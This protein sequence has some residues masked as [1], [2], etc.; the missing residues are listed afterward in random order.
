M[1]PSEEQFE[2][3]I[4]QSLLSQGYQQRQPS[5]YDKARCLLPA[6][7]VAFVVATQPQEWAKLREHHRDA[8]EA[9]FR[10]RVASEVAKRGALD[11]LRK[12]VKD[13]GSR[14]DLAY[15]RP[16][17][18]LNEELRHKYE[19][20]LFSVV[21][22]LGYSEKTE[23][24]L[25]LTLFLNGLPIFTAEL[26]TPFTGQNADNAMAQYRKDRDPRE[27]LFAFGRCLAHFAVDPTR[28]HMTTRLAGSKTRFLPFNRGNQGGAGNP[29]EWEKYATAYL[30]EDIWS[31]DGA[32]SLVRHFIVDIPAA[33]GSPRNVIFPRYHQLDA[34]RR[35][36]SDAREKGAGQRYLIQHSAGSGKSNTIAWL[37]HQLSVLHDDEDRRV[38]DSIVVVTDRRVLDKQL[39]DTILQFEQTRGVV[40]N[41]DKTSRQLRSALESGK[42]IVVTTLQKF[43]VIADEIGS[44]PGNRFAVIIDEA[45]SSQGGARASRT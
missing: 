44:L 27:P 36:V 21:R 16:S 41:I 9:H 19:A 13:Y 40:E 39:Q 12:G 34:V 32:L 37:A 11:V 35:L 23:Q 38:F 14:F 5:D 24:S 10:A 3:T 18:G 43:P 8:T 45:H 7:L 6:D 29:D 25:D 28:V 15:F 4:E 33:N 42:N 30:W 31:P 1:K 26:K 2:D 17:S 20:N 22:Q